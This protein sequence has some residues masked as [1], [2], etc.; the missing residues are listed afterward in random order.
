[1]RGRA[2]EGQF[3]ADADADHHETELVVEAV[4][5]HAAQVVLDHRI[6]DGERRHGGA[7]GNEDLGAGIAAGQGV[8]RELGRERREHD[9]AAWCGLRIGVLKPVVQQ[10]KGALD[11]ECQEDQPG[12]RRDQPQF[13]ECDRLCGVE[14]E[15]RAGQQKHA[16]ADLD[17]EIPHP[18]VEG[19]LGAAR[20]DQEYR[21]DRRPLPIEEQRDEIA[22]EYRADRR[23]GI[24]EAC[25][26]LHH[27]V[28]VERVENAEKAGDQEDVAED[29]AQPIDAQRDQRQAEHADLAE[30]AVGQ[31]DQLR[32][33]QRRQRQ[34]IGRA[35][36]PFEQGHK[37]C[38]QN[39]DQ[40]GRNLTDH[41]SPPAA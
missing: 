24:D 13:V 30:I 34:H 37:Q 32:E 2:V 40:A 15:E 28:V 27:V 20:P 38:P 18:R 41:S 7:D 19:T 10:R 16:R 14:M 11:P 3:A 31:R 29:R 23:P 35:H 6:E 25:D 39:Q 36:Q 26:V 5:Q 12:S 22:G 33:R 8:D 9:R 4:G 1:M 21:G 17:D